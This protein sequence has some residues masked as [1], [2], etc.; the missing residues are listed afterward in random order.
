MRE[1]GEAGKEDEDVAVRP[2]DDAAVEQ[3]EEHARRVEPFGDRLLSEKRDRQE[4][5]QDEA[6]QREK[7]D[8]ALLVPRVPDRGKPVAGEFLQPLQQ[9]DF[10]CAARCIAGDQASRWHIL[11]VLRRHE[12][13][14]RRAQP[15]QDS[16]ERLLPDDGS[17]VCGP[18]G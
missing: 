12:L 14:L 13:E 3:H 11:D 16:N 2:L 18:W 15:S 5:K 6:R 17:R 4:K 1:D 10:G 9:R 8:R 7:K